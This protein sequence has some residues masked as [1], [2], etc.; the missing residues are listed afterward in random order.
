MGCYGIG[1]GRLLAAAI[2]QNSDDKGIVWPA[3]IAPYQIHLV[4]LSPD[5][6]QVVE[7]AERLYAE[8]IA[9]GQEVLMDDRMESAGVKFNDADL[10]GM[11]L[12]VTISPR[13]LKAGTVELKLRTGSEVTAVPL[14]VRCSSRSSGRWTP[15]PRSALGSA[16]AQSKGAWQRISAA[17]PL[18]SPPMARCKS[19]FYDHASAAPLTPASPALN[20]PWPAGSSAQPLALR[21]EPAAATPGNVARQGRSGPLRWSPG[22]RSWPAS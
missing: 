21:Q 12:R 15:W 20:R 4:V 7:A 11:P 17:R 6:P 1:T 10:L 22:C 9:A 3:P 19:T 16:P 13:G 5:N 18:C 14:E 2:E 8:L